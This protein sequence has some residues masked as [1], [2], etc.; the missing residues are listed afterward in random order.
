MRLLK[1]MKDGGEESTVSG[2]YFVEIK[3]LFTIVLLRFS[4]KSREAFHT[5]AFNAISWVLRGKL[6]ENIFY[7]GEWFADRIKVYEPSFLPIITPRTRFHKV[8]SDGDTWAFSLRG[9]W[10]DTWRE[11]LPALNVFRTLTHGRKVV[12]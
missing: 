11:F 4:G 1:Y 12:A 5:H 2:L 10:V 7:N 9:P 8:D 3:S 6:T